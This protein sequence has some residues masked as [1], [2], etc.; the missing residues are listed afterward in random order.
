MGAGSSEELFVFLNMV[1]I[2]WI[3]RVTSAGVSI[4]QTD[5]SNDANALL[6]VQ[7]RGNHAKT[8]ESARKKTIDKRQS[9]PT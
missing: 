2:T 3:G 4:I 7:S 1:R 8:R 9:K 6:H 5:I